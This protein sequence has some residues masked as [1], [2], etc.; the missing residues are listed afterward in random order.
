MNNPAGIV[1]SNTVPW[2]PARRVQALRVH[3]VIADPKITTTVKQ[4]TVTALDH[5]YS[6][7]SD[8]Y[9]W[10]RTHLDRVFYTANAAHS[11]P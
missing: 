8:T 6:P 11:H 2:D 3:V 9:Y 4:T 5:T 10:A 1:W 7:P